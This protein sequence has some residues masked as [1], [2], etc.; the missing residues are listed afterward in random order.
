MLQN[1]TWE[2]TP[3]LLSLRKLGDTWFTQRI[4]SRTDNFTKTLDM[5]EQSLIWIDKKPMRNKSRGIR[6][7]MLSVE[8]G[9]VDSKST[10]IVLSI[11]SK[12]K[13]STRRMTTEKNIGDLTNLSLRL[14]GSTEFMI[15]QLN[16]TIECHS[17]PDLSKRRLENFR[18]SKG[19]QMLLQL[20]RRI[21]TENKWIKLYL[22]G[23][24]QE[25]PLSN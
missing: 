7:L 4:S 19:L 25:V 1:Q 13:D 24:Y 3:I 16:M 18:K 9:K 12:T 10:H 6:E 15:S 8:A 20:F 2:T 22:T 21:N 5:L 17:S 23:Q 11:V 14:T